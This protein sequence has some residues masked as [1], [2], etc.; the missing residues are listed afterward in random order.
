V[1]GAQQASLEQQVA[2]L[3]DQVSFL[4]RRLDAYDEAW[5]A[6]H[7]A[8]EGRR[9]RPA[10]SEVGE[11]RARVAHHDAKFAAVFDTMRQAADAAGIS[12]P[13]ARHLRAI[14]DGDR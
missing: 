8:A 7:G 5:G 12:V 1:T 6:I 13:R 14:P 2:A 10:A 3:A 4:R 11:L 9:L